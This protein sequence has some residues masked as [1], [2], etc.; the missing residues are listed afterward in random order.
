MKEDF[1]YEFEYRVGTLKGKDAVIAP[2]LEAA[3]DKFFKRQPAASVTK[4]TRRRIG[5][6][7]AL[8]WTR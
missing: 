3:H 7:E 6:G 5:D 1:V 4:V 2:H 8:R